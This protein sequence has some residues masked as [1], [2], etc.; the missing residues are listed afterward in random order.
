M[1]LKEEMKN[2]TTWEIVVDFLH[3]IWYM[4]W[5][6]GL[7]LVGFFALMFLMNWEWWR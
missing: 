2:M 5:R 3:I 1:S 7:F 6:F 4:V